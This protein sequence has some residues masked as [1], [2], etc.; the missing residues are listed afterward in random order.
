MEILRTAAAA[1]G[2]GLAVTGCATEPSLTY[3]RPGVIVQHEYDDR[4]I[5]AVKPIIIDPEHFLITIRQ[6]GL[7][8]DNGGT[9]CQDT[10]VEVSERYYTDY[11][12]G[13][14]LSADEVNALTN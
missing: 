5:V 2:I 4:D 1:V 7:P 10:T 11:P 13:T 6:C 3:D 8:A 14:E 9:E 12:D